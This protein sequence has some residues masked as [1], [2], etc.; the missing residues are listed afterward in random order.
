[1]NSMELIMSRKSIRTFDGRP[2]T[3]S[4]KEKLRVF[5]ATIS[6][7]YGIPV[8][9]VLLD[10]EEHGLSSPVIQGEHLYIA[11][12]VQKVEHCEEAFGYSFEQ[13]VLYAWSLG[14]GTTWIGGTMKRELFEAAAQ[15]KEGELMPIVSP[16]GYPA[17]EKSEVDAKLRNSVHG[18][19][20]LPA[21]ELFFD[22]DFSRPL[23]EMD[24]LLEAVRWAP[25]AANMQPCRVVRCGTKY[26]LYEKHMQGY[27]PGA[28][29]DVQR[30][31]MGIALCH[32]LCVTDGT[33]GIA[34]PGI[35]CPEDTE[36]IVTATV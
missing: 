7:P 23:Q 32:L 9:F 6:N 12:K 33:C 29:W 10:A 17:K 11:G 3:D 5:I 21:A 20:R 15:V 18:D 4:D 26:H 8:K 35:P 14:I 28:P 30:I 34:D 2:L 22:G 31:D 36:Y 1:M 13:L 24:P 19:D 16:L 27:K 25:T